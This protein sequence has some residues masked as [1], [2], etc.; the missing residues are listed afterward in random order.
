MIG[1]VRKDRTFT[2][3][4]FAIAAQAFVNSKPL[5]DVSVLR[6]FSGNLSLSCYRM[7]ISGGRR[8]QFLS[9]WTVGNVNDSIGC[10]DDELPLCGEPDVVGA[11]RKINTFGDHNFRFATNTSVHTKLPVHFTILGHAMP[12][13]PACS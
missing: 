4:N 11:V 1:T 9:G 2:N 8:A 10:L 13:P 7:Q 6:H 12:H 3:Q 5:T